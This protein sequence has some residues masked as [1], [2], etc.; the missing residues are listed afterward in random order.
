M[1]TYVVN[2]LTTIDLDG[3]TSKQLADALG[4]C[5]ARLGV[6]VVYRPYDCGRDGLSGPPYIDLETGDERPLR[7]Y[8]DLVNQVNWIVEQVIEDVV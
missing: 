7:A 6:E 4:P 1:Y 8:D 3:W 2:K 5:L